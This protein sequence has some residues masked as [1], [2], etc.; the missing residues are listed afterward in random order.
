MSNQ[1]TTGPFRLHIDQD[2]CD[3]TIGILHSTPM[4]RIRIL[5]LWE[6]WRVLITYDTRPLKKK[7]RISNLKCDVDHVNTS[8]SLRSIIDFFPNRKFLTHL[9][10]IDK[11]LGQISE[12]TWFW[13]YVIIESSI[14]P[15]HVSILFLFSYVVRD[16]IDSLD[17]LYALRYRRKDMI[18]GYSWKQTK[19]RLDM[20]RDSPSFVCLIREV[21]VSWDLL[22]GLIIIF[23]DHLMWLSLQIENRK[24][25]REKRSTCDP[26]SC[27]HRY[28]RS[29]TLLDSM[30]FLPARLWMIA[31]SASELIVI[32]H[33]T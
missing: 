17:H 4:W 19:K 16:D 28:Q 7:I 23:Y 14:L 22:L 11:T 32:M 25:V 30:H 13:I 10:F 15:V 21:E 33:V 24:K 18:L 1:R 8:F 2:D 20:Y 29:V 31:S 26:V 5:D 12:W 9:T 6:S 27:S 3:S